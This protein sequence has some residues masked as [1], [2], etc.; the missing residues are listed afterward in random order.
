MVDTRLSDADVGDILDNFLSNH[1]F[2]GCKVR[3]NSPFDPTEVLF[4]TDPLA[5]FPNGWQAE[6]KPPEVVGFRSSYWKMHLF[7]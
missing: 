5:A 7:V 3:A 4:G 1:H 2:A 6:P